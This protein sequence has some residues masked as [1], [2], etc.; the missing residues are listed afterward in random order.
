MAG[1]P[2][3]V[4]KRAVA[5]V[6]LRPDPAAPIQF[7]LAPDASVLVRTTVKDF[8]EVTIGEFAEGDTPAYFVARAAL[9]PTGP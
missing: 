4:A 8:Y 2:H 6:R 5:A 9:E 3:R 1:S 7:A